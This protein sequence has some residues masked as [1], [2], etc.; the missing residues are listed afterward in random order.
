MESKH[1]TKTIT[2]FALKAIIITIC[3]GFLIPSLTPDM[4]WAKTMQ[5][6]I[7]LASF[8]Q[9]PS[10]L[11]KMAEQQEAEKKYKDAAILIDLAIGLLEMSCASTQTLSKYQ[12][13]RDYL[14]SLDSK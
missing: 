6:K 7:I 5:G 13:K 10:T 9:N 4:K 14:N 3:I 1:A 8:I 11:W 2:Y 12:R